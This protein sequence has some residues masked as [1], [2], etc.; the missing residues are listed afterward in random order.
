MQSRHP[1]GMLDGDQGQALLALCAA[2]LLC[3]LFFDTFIYATCWVLYWLWMLA[4][5]PRIHAWAAPKINLLADVANAAEGVSFDEWLTVMNE[6]SGVLLLL[7]VPIL[8]AG[9]VALAQHPALGFR[10]KR[11]VD[12]ATL[13]ALLSRFAPSVS[14]VLAMNGGRDGLMNDTTPENAW[15]LRP[16]EFAAWHNLITRQTLDRE[17]CETVFVAQLGARLHEDKA[18]LPACWAAHERAL[19]AVIGLQVFCN[20]RQGAARLADD[21]N[22]SCLQRGLLRRRIDPLPLWRLCEV[23]LQRVLAAPGVTDWLAMHVSVRSALAGLYGRDLRLPSVRFRWLKGV[24]RTLWYA[25]H[26]ADT[27]KVF[28]EGAGVLAQARAERH[29]HRLGLPR[30]GVMVMTAVDGLQADLESIGLVHPREPVVA[31]RSRRDNPQG[32]VGAFSI[33]SESEGEA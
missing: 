4:D 13:P 11:P 22:R 7:L 32:L 29:A 23:P 19:L 31:S 33:A 18:F 30:P 3:W 25:L 1:Q 2:A 5:F 27:A 20:D 24:D 8:I 14:P 17:A 21:L 9:A 26:S 15:A 10:S 6:T 28:V 12:I 16:E